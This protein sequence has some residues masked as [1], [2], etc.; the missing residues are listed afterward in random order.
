MTPTTKRP[1][2]TFRPGIRFGL[3]TAAA[4]TASA[5]FV[6]T[7]LRPLHAGGCLQSLLGPLNG[8]ADLLQ[9]PGTNALQ[10][11]Y[12]LVGYLPSTTAWFIVL[13]LNAIFYFVGGFVFRILWCWMIGPRPAG[14]ATPERSS[15]RRFLG[16]GVKAL[17]GGVA[18]G[19][20]YG[21]IV[22][23]R[24][25]EVTHRRIALRDLPRELD[26]LRVVQ[27]TDIHHSPWFSRERVREV[28]DAANELRPDL[29][30]LTGDYAD[31]A[32]DYLAPVVAE[33][34]R[35]R[36][37]I[38][39]VAVLGN[40]DWFDDASLAREEFARA[41]IPLID[42]ARRVLTP[43]RRLVANAERGLALC[44][45]GDLL[46]DRPDYR[47]AL[48]GLPSGMPRLLLSHNPDVGEEPGL[49]RSGLRVDL[50]ISGH[51]HGG[52]VKL[53]FLG[54][55]VTMSRYGQKYREGL[56]EGPVCPVFICRGIGFSG[57]P[58]RL[59]ATPELAVLEFRTARA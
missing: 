15:R 16:L 17:G 20:G 52:Q 42:N 24:R 2:S 7:V 50:I 38:G 44:G 8:L 32:A 13:A 34:T 35:L 28:V 43:E 39:T 5:V 22:E 29:V 36:P 57:L 40:H 54:A 1:V 10:R 46:E 14:V 21:L 59:G 33:F 27:I 26:G 19:V 41:G 53:P 4:V 49:T 30:L 37:L 12:S 18:A 55:P 47:L 23:P 3:F 6:Q 11:A 31:Q 45:V 51:T 25:L 56:V 58:I 48:D 9:F